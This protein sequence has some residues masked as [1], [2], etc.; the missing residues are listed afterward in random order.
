MK[1]GVLDQLIEEKIAEMNVQIENLNEEFIIIFWQTVE[2]IY[3]FV[4]YYERQG[5]IWKALY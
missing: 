2:E 4:N 1:I 5:L 3:K